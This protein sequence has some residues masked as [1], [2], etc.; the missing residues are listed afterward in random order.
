MHNWCFKKVCSTEIF[1]EN[2]KSPTIK[3][4]LWRNVVAATRLIGVGLLSS[5]NL[6][7]K[8]VNAWFTTLLPYQ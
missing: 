4:A 6:S 3:A 2:K 7:N 8:N 1:V 5:K